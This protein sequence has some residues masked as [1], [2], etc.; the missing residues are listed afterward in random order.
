M[1]SPASST[2]PATFEGCTATLDT[3]ATSS[4]MLESSS[5]EIETPLRS[6]LSITSTVTQ[7]MVESAGQA[8]HCAT[9]CMPVLGKT[10]GPGC[11][12]SEVFS[13]HG[14]K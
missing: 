4:T 1:Q 9:G 11:S 8:E 7:W 5:A 3:P 13:G 14:F 6:Q 2:T 10:L 12:S